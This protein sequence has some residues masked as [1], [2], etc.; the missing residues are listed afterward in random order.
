MENRPINTKYT[1][2]KKKT[3]RNIFIALL[4]L[5][6]IPATAVFGYAYYLTSKIQSI[7]INDSK[8]N[9]SIGGS[10]TPVDTSGKTIKEVLGIKPHVEEEIKKLP[11]AA[12]GKIRNI[13]L[14]GIDS[15]S[16]SGRSDVIMIL[17]LDQISKKIKLSSI[18]RDSYVEIEGYGMDK[19]NHAY[20]YGG[21]R[22]ALNTV[23]SNFNLNITDVVVVNFWQML[24]IIDTMGGIPIYLT[25]SE[26]SY[27]GYS[28]GEGTY[29]LDGTDVLSYSRIRALDND[30]GRTNRQR[31][32]MTA[33]VNKMK[34]LPI[35]QI[36]GVAE[37]ILPLVWTTLK[38]PDILAT[39]IGVVTTGYDI[40]G[41]GFPSESE[42]YGVTENGVWYMGFDQDTVNH[43]L[44]TFIYNQ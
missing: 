25:N 37:N 17:T 12:N 38:T 30:Y 18:Q 11:G 44:L 40:E 36:P 14:L 13:L 26:A 31:T 1:R 6:A 33:I 21:A 10:G 16:D 23:N 19:I 2:K 39:G 27:L 43:E 22:L 32:V 5:I 34:S 35:T 7:D 42:S 41:K 4:L 8:W 9:E 29:N 24:D 20:A 3:L 15:N 28:G